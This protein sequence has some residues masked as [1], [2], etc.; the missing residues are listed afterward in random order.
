[1]EKIV[2]STAEVAE[3]AP[4]SEGPAR[5]EPKLPPAVAW[6]AK[7]AM[8][9]LVL[10]LPLLCLIAIIL[11]F[12]MRGLPPRTRF[13]WTGFLATLLTTSGLLTC[14]VAILAISLVP[15]PSFVSRNLTELDEKSDFPHLPSPAAI[16]AKDVSQELKPL[17]AVI[18]PTHRSWLHD[19]DVAT[20]SFGA[21]SLLQVTSAGYLFV[22]ARH[23]ISGSFRQAGDNDL[24]ALVA[25][26]SGT[27]A[28]AEVVA[29]HQ[30][31]DLLLLWLPRGSGHGD[32]SQ[33]VATDADVTQGE[34][35]FVIGHP[36]GLRF[37]LSTGVISR[38]DSHMI[39]MTAPASPGNSGG[40]VFDDKGNLVAIVSSVIDKHND[41][42]AENINFAVRADAL[43]DESGWK[44][45]GDGQQHLLDFQTR[46]KQNH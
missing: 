26:A 11:R 9:P 34:N 29:Q 3:T 38:T 21:G 19:R 1:M 39:Q 12:A 23:V 25:M 7:L 41:P 36:E 32:F 43:L 16:S 13:A 46:L 22:T 30:Y 18:S 2:I 31:L 33:P 28:G 5:L 40:P 20:G 14:V 27:W 10:V 15:P 8:W 4:L 24:H 37:S 6:W 35:V 17:V 44:F 42:N 45:F